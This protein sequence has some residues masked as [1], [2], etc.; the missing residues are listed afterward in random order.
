MIGRLAGKVLHRM[1]VGE[2]FVRGQHP[3]VPRSGRAVFCMSFDEFANRFPLL[4]Q[5]H[6]HEPGVGACVD[7][8]IAFRDDE[9]VE[10]VDLGGQP[11][12]ETLREL[13]LGRDADSAATAVIGQQFDDALNVIP[14]LLQHLL[15]R[16]RGAV[17]DPVGRH[18]PHIVPHSQRHV[19]SHDGHS[20]AGTFEVYQDLSGAF[21]F[22][23]VDARGAV[24][25]RGEPFES[26]DAAIEG[27]TAV[28]RAATGA[29]VVEVAPEA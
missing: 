26:R 18:V 3:E 7:L 9:T 13:G 25:A 20:E 2:G 8:V 11:L 21:R 6:E 5:A 14:G 15:D 10:R 19:R 27:T 23:L 24:V 29:S 28:Q 16:G 22:K 12:E 1:L 17:P 4:P